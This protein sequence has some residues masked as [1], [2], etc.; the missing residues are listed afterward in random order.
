[1][2]QDIEKNKTPSPNGV[3]SNW[4]RFYDV[5]H[6]D[7]LSSVNDLTMC[8]VL[9]HGKFRPYRV[10]EVMSTHAAKAGGRMDQ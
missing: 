2:L 3:L 10:P 5:T 6:L 8:I 7:A 4:I 1:M 9:S